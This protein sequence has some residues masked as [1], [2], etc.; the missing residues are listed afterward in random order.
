MLEQDSSPEPAAAAVAASRDT[1]TA[2][3]SRP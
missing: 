3:V 1:L 2:V